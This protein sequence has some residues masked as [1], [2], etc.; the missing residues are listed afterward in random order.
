[1]KSLIVAILTV[2][3]WFMGFSLNFSSGFAMCVSFILNMPLKPARRNPI[4][5]QPLAGGCS[6]PF[7]NAFYCICSL[8]MNLLWYPQKEPGNVEYFINIYYGYFMPMNVEFIDEIITWVVPLPSCSHQDF[9]IFSRGSRTKPSFATLTWKGIT[10]TTSRL[11]CFGS[12]LQ[13]SQVSTDGKLRKY[14][15]K[16]TMLMGV[17]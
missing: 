17:Y 11:D 8:I 2:F 12:K 6:L 14:L 3:P 1:M 9:H 16:S 7:T 15:L 13:A 4:Q 10:Q 5:N